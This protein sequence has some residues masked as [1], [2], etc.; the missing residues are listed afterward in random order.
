MQ[1]TTQVI[2]YTKFDVEQVTTNI[3]EYNG[4][5]PEYQLDQSI[6][7]IKKNLEEAGYSCQARE[8]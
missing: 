3:A 7:S 6:A 5:Y 2:D 4:F 8:Y 1:K